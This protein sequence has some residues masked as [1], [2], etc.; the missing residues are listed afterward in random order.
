MYEILTTEKW[1]LH[2]KDKHRA[3]S[4]AF[5]SEEDV[6][7]I[8]DCTNVDCEGSG[9]S[10]LVEQQFYSPYYKSCCGKYNV[11]CSQVGGCVLVSPGMG[12]PASDHACMVAAGLFESDKWKVDEGEPW[13]QLLYDA[14]VSAPTKTAAKLVGCDLVS[15]GYVRTNAKNTLSYQQRTSNY[16]ISSLRMRV[17]NFI[18]IIKNR[19]QLLRTTIQSEDIGMMDELVYLCFML[20]NFG[21]PIIA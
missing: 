18:G 1:W 7:V 2:P 8:S 13:P 12:G 9:L 20:H 14:G 11:C 4:K 10:E 5:S 6:L 17:E 3:K 21:T 15:S 16:N 19:F